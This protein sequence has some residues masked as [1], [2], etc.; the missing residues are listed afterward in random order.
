MVE[1]SDI[2]L[3]QDGGEHILPAF[4]PYRLPVDHG[5]DLV[6]FNPDPEVAFRVIDDIHR[7]LMKG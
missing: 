7:C 2:A 1:K 3:R 4:A 5:N 6:T